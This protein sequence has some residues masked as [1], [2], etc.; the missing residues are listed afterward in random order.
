MARS[1]SAR[2]L[3]SKR[4]AEAYRRER[5]ATGLRGVESLEQRAMMAV[6][7]LSSDTVTQ[8]LS[9]ATLAAPMNAAVAPA[10]PKDVKIGMD[11]KLTWIQ[12]E[13][14]GPQMPFFAPA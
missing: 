9:P 5:M 13:D 10:A 1:R 3:V 8:L 7:V 4:R 11:V 6:G 2:N 12:T 14:G